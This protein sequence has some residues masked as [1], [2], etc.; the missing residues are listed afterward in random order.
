VTSTDINEYLRAAAEI[1]PSSGAICQASG[2]FGAFH[3]LLMES[4]SRIG[5]PV[6][7]SNTAAKRHPKPKSRPSGTRSS[8]IASPHYWS[9]RV[10]RESNALD[11]DKGVFNL[12]DPKKIAAS[13]KQ[14]AQ[15]SR[16][17]KAEPYRSALSMLV[18]YI[19][20]AGRNLP[21][22]RKRILE[23]A[24]GELKKLFGLDSRGHDAA[25]PRGSAR[26][27]R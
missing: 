18:F 26:A 7:K 12:R 16:R 2:T 25:A 8:R 23:R 22:N 21:A 3:R 15:R 9:G 1:E 17:R 27:S 4:R 5:S 20:R 11:L 10:T 14:S 13:L 19:N 24:K 6:A